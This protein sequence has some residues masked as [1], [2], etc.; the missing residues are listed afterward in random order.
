MILPVSP[1]QLASS[2]FPLTSRSPRSFALRFLPFTPY[3]SNNNKWFILAIKER[4][5]CNNHNNNTRHCKMRSLNWSARILS[6]GASPWK[7]KKLPYWWHSHKMCIQCVAFISR[8]TSELTS[9]KQ[10]SHANWLSSQR[11]QS[12][13][14]NAEQIGNAGIRTKT[15]DHERRTSIVPEMNTRDSATKSKAKKTTTNQK[16]RVALTMLT[17]YLR[18][19]TGPECICF[20]LL[21]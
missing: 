19:L 6:H 12:E 20:A 10:K 13:I 14:I 5:R 17:F 3:F 7:W 2:V 21:L 18:E 15:T 9:P 1:Y 4:S 8:S 11:K 16:K